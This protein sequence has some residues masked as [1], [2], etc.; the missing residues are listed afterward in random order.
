MKLI[1]GWT[2]ESVM[3]QIKA[4]NNGT[5]CVQGV[6]QEGGYVSKMCRYRFEGNVCY[7]GAFIPDQYYEKEMEGRE[8]TRLL[9]EIP[10]LKNAMPFNDAGM[11]SLQSFHDNYH[12]PDLHADT[13]KFLEVNVKP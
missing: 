11:H 12:G 8:I 3:K 5:R 13:L 9:K 7:A 10:E 6:E 2:I 1:N 4:R